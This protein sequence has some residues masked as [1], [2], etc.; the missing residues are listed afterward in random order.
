[1]Y[2]QV[3]LGSVRMEPAVTRLLERYGDSR[4]E[5]PS[6]RGRA[7]LAVVILDSRGVPVSPPA[8]AVSS[9]GWGVMTALNGRLADLAR[10]PAV[11][12]TLADRLEA[13]L[14]GPTKAG[15][16]GA[17]A[18]DCP[19][20][21][22]MLVRGYE[23][24]IREFGL[25]D[26]LVEPPTF[27][28]CSYLYYRNPDPPEPLLLN[29]FFLGDLALARRLVASGQVPLGLDRYLG[30]RPLT[31]KQDLL[32]SEPALR[33]AV[34]PGL[35]PPSRW[36]GPGRHPLCLMQ[37]AAVNLA[38][39][40]LPKGGLLGVNGPP[41]TGKTT[42][43]RDI[44]AHVVAARAE[45]MSRFDD[46]ADAFTH[47]GER[48]N[49]GGGAWLHLYRVCPDLRGYELLVASSNNKAVENVSTE[50]PALG[51]IAADATGL[52]YF[53]VLSDAVHDRPTWGLI[54]AVLGNATNRGRFRN[55]FWWDNEVGM[56]RY[57]AAAS[58]T[59][60]QIEEP[61]PGTGA[62]TCRLP[63][64]VAAEAPPTTHD[65]AVARW[66][67]ARARFREAL[68][69]SRGWQRWLVALEQDTTKLPSLVA[70]ERTALQQ[71]AA[72][73]HAEAVCRE[74]LL[75]M[76]ATAEVAAEALVLATTAMDSHMR[77]RPGW[78]ARLFGTPAARRWRASA[79]AIR[80]AFKRCA[81]DLAAARADSDRLRVEYEQAV[82]ETRVRQEERE[83]ASAGRSATEGR[84]EAARTRGV[85]PVDGT[86]FQLP[87]AEKQR[88][89][90]WFPR[91]AQV[92]RDQ[93]FQ[94]AIELH[95]AFID[96]AAKPVRHNLGVLMNVMGGRRLRAGPQESLLGDLWATLFLVVPL[97]STTF[98][99]VE[100]MLGRLPPES[101]GWLLVDEAGQALPQAAVGALLRTRG[102]LVVG[103][104]LQIEPVVALPDALTRA[105]SLQM[106][107]D[108]DRYAAPVASV[109]TL[110]DAASPYG[111]ELQ[112]WGGS[113]TVGVPLLVHR[114]CS[115]PMFGI[116]NAVA[117]AG[118]MVSVKTPGR[119]PI[120]DV[121]GPSA[122][123][124]VEGAPEDKWC[125]EE[126]ELVLTLLRQLAA[127]GV[128]PDLY[129]VTP[130]VIVAERLRRL[131]RE[132]GVL[133]GW[134]PDRTSRDWA[135][136]RIG[137]VH[138]AQGREAEVVILVLGA[139][140]A[141]QAGARNWAGGRPNLLNV[142]V[143]RAKEVLYVVGN[144]QLWREAGVFRELD[145]Q[146]SQWERAEAGRK[147]EEE[148]QRQEAER[149]RQEQE[150][151]KGEADAAEHQWVGEEARN[152]AEEMP[153][154]ERATDLFGQPLPPEQL[155]LF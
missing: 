49:A 72:S 65:E 126:G 46:P 60:Q 56:G 21:W 8:V 53:Q 85:L 75:Q 122:W 20:D 150:R 94:A 67:K 102:A 136:E 121:L 90:P 107:V 132:S 10:W 4:P 103:D 55:T 138:T 37:Q 27:A 50:L 120:R 140:S 57:L 87:H 18:A 147:R 24:L 77:T 39:R 3:V 80:A 51:A 31:E 2:Y 128:E 145:A 99:S 91:E 83:K 104:P 112:T 153:V 19:V 110:A 36:P 130:F 97:V 84:I 11:E 92:A 100:R 79:D 6:A 52:R 35:T 101:L 64:L 63:K 149:G 124:H 88:A 108:P 119:S 89:T 98:A 76:E 25:P 127:A 66:R 13:V 58:G 43:L 17:G 28:V 96:A 33:E 62:V 70:A 45:A 40:D 114:R 81:S 82:A 141:A 29:S 116:A 74:K 48:I 69:R 151:R 154:E 118:M 142:A 137:T 123:M 73:T 14:R 95:R 86:F 105:I 30:R 41:G 9:F 155:R 134:A 44:V 106:G 139:P 12:P 115:E 111:C 129:I 125:E 71:L 38:A 5:R 32:T 146:L 68:E 135:H 34:F 47:S 78:L 113:R 117:Y 1:M 61:D 133:N 148:R 26:D 131:V 152:R 42:L 22:S 15:Q 54:A 23:L 16:D 144:R 93:V 143:T 109:Q 7:A 59:P